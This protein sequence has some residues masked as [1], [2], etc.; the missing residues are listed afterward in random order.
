MIDANPARRSVTLP[1]CCS[2]GLLVLVAM[3]AAASPLWGDT[4]AKDAAVPVTNPRANGESNEWVFDKSLYTNNMQT[5]D[6]TRQYAKDA[7][8]FRDPNAIY[9]SAHGPYPFVSN[10]YDP[11]RYYGHRPY[12]PSGGANPL[13]PYPHYGPNSHAYSPYPFY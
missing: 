2:I 12:G 7:K 8:P 4:D 13:G 10:F 6:R 9:N 5:G 3:L 11:Y 1:S